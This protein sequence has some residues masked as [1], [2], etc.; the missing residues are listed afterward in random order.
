DAGTDTFGFR[1]FDPGTGLD[2]ITDFQTVENV[3]GTDRLDLSELLV[4]AG[5][6]TLTD[7]LTDFIQ[8]IEGGSD[9]TVSFNSAGNGGAGTYV[10]I[11]SLTGVTA[12]TI[13]ILV[14]AVAAVETV[15]VA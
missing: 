6:N 14:D 15:A 11:A 7:V 12:G 10:D 4:D 1:L 2:T 13:N 9:A 3:N 8:V 5:Y